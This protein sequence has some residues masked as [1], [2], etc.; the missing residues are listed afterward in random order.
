MTDA[1]DKRRQR[2]ADESYRVS[3]K[4]AKWRTFFT[5]WQVGTRLFNDHECKALRNQYE[6]YILMRADINA[7]T[8]L[9]IKKG[10]FSAEEFTEA[11]ITETKQLDHMYEENYPGFSTSL[12]G[13]HMQMPAAG[14]TMY[15]LGF[16][17]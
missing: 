15:R 16:P 8:G 10:V 7:L 11:L 2:L 14:E 13:L 12:D 4:L 3:N 5:S 9:L 6:M 1:D 17:P